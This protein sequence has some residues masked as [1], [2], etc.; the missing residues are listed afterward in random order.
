MAVQLAM[1]FARFRFL[2]NSQG[3]LCVLPGCVCVI[4]KNASKRFNNGQKDSTSVT[5]WCFVKNGD[6]MVIQKE[7]Q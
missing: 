6:S 3:D 7:M 4:K 2:Q 1:C 5:E